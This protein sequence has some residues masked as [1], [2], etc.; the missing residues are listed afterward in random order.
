MYCEIKSGTRW[1]E[2]APHLSGSYKKRGR[3]TF[4]GREILYRFLLAH[5]RLCQLLRILVSHIYEIMV[6]VR[7][8]SV[9]IATPVESHA[10]PPLRMGM[11]NLLF[12]S[13]P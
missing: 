1:R 10:A 11:G 5:H 7:R 9:A 12:S 4:R 13:C 3:K 6:T 2:G 8:E